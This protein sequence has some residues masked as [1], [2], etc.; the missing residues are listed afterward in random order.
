MSESC[1]VQSKRQRVT[2]GCCG[3][4]GQAMAKGKRKCYNTVARGCIEMRRYWSRIHRPA[5]EFDPI[6]A[7]R[8]RDWQRWQLP[9]QLGAR[10]VTPHCRSL[11]SML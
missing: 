10:R 3:R 7:G 6:R 9:G 8:S 4:K 11:G 2:S 1:V 5:C